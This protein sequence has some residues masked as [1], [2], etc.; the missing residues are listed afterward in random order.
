MSDPRQPHHARERA[1]RKQVLGSAGIGLVVVVALAAC[2]STEMDVA[3]ANRIRI[4]QTTKDEATQ[5]FAA[6]P[7]QVRQTERTE[8]WLYIDESSLLEDRLNYKI[9]IKFKDGV[10]IDCDI[11]TRQFY[12]RTASKSSRLESRLVQRKCGEN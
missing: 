5:M 1:I 10:V 12:S 6:T 11:V 2:A 7:L 8:T 4:G 3:A 9:Q